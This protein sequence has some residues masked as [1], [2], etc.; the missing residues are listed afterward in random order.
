MR[1]VC[2]HFVTNTCIYIYMYQLRYPREAL[3]FFAY[4]SGDHLDN[5]KLLEDIQSSLNT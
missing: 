4:T 3:Q 2:L 5:I 1:I